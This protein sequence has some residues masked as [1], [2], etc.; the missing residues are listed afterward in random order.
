[1]ITENQD[2]PIQTIAQRNQAM[3]RR[4]F[5]QP[6]TGLYYMYTDAYQ[7]GRI[8][9]PTP[10]EI[11]ACIP[12]SNGFS[13][14]LENQNYAS[15]QYLDTLLY[16][17]RVTRKPEHAEE[18]R[19]VFNGLRHLYR[20]SGSDSFVPRGVLP[21][22]RSHYPDVSID[23][24]SFWLMAMWR[25][26]RSEVSSHDERR[27]LRDVFTRF[28]LD[29][30]KHDWTFRREDGL[31]TFWAN[32]NDPSV[33]RAPLVFMFLLLAAYDCTGEKRFFDHYLT[34]LEKD[35]RAIIQRLESEAISAEVSWV[36]SQS[37]WLLDCLQ[38]LEDD[39]A[40]KMVYYRNM[41]KIA[42]NAPNQLESYR[43]FDWRRACVDFD[44]RSLT[45]RNCLFALICIAFCPDA[46]FAR[47]MIPLC[48]RVIRH[49][50]YR[51]DGKIIDL[52]DA[53]PRY[54][55]IMA[56]HGL[57]AY[58]PDAEVGEDGTQTPIPADLPYYLHH[59]VKWYEP[60]EHRY[61]GRWIENHDPGFRYFYQYPENLRLRRQKESER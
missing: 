44:H 35:D 43:D 52:L 8:N 9:L 7:P 22:L 37:I 29:A 53:V 59:A 27:D 48:D 54:Y 30:E 46:G 39:P 14:P 45:H 57:L 26:Y 19:S 10:A 15:S 17:Y 40:I 2:V 60:L 32:L 24:I 11:E 28:A 47:S 33:L 6:E 42:R 56:S 51:R 12:C 41:I 23:H 16:R 31:I 55:W 4:N 49:Y 34:I 36:S 5:Y 3:M 50:D 38:Q 25:Y 21:D 20:V 58:D 1:M 13:T 61:V 18:A